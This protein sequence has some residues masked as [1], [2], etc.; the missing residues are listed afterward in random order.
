MDV[1]SL[2]EDVGGDPVLIAQL[3]RVNAYRKQLAT[4]QPASD[5]HRKH[6]D[7][8]VLA[9]LRYFRREW[10]RRLDDRFR[11]LVA[12]YLGAVHVPHLAETQTDGVAAFH[13]RRY[14][15]FHIIDETCWFPSAVG[16]AV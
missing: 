15:D 8:L 12:F 11:S 14:H 13:E 16:L 9:V 7:T 1:P 2:T 6:G 5:Q 3:D 4:P 10:M